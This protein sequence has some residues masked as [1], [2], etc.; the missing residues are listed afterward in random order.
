MHVDEHPYSM[1]VDGHRVELREEPA[2]EAK[3]TIRGSQSAWLAALGPDAD[4]S[5][6]DIS[7]DSRLADALLD[8]VGAQA[9]RA[10]NAA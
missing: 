2:G 4:R 8:G 9:R 10:V 3:A 5:G 1:M 6:L 7:G